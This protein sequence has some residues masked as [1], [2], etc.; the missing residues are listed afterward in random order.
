[1]VVIAEIGCSGLL[2]LW[3]TG[4]T[5]IALTVLFVAGA[6]LLAR[7]S[8]GIIWLAE[9]QSGVR[10][11]SGLL[12]ASC[13]TALLPDL[14]DLTP[15]PAK[16]LAVAGL[17]MVAVSVL[18]TRNVARVPVVSIL[19]TTAMAEHGEA[20]AASPTEIRVDVVHVTRLGGGWIGNLY[21]LMVAWSVMTLADSL[22]GGA[23]NTGWNQISVV[24]VVAYM[25]TL[26]AWS[27]AQLRRQLNAES[28][29][30]HMR[31][32]H[33]MIDPVVGDVQAL[34]DR[35]R[36]A[37]RLRLL[38]FSAGSLPLLVLVFGSV[39]IPGSQM[40]AI[41]VVLF[42]IAVVVEQGREFL[43]T[44]S[45]ALVAEAASAPGFVVDAES[46]DA[47]SILEWAQARWADVNARFR[48]VVLAFV[49][50]S[51]LVNLFSIVDFATKVVR[52]V[53]G[54]LP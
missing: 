44:A 43:T 31:R 7:I 50:V 29:R 48:Y 34:L 6:V 2:G 21:A 51:F 26:V 30:D 20:L 1:M 47:S 28:W 46:P 49:V 45:D 11:V 39:R 24:A 5:T 13:A 35:H 10:L 17:P 27:E 4:N 16:A 15:S 36:R 42:V 18:A 33:Q 41:V 38:V 14:S 22:S 32:A 25:L 9:N 19:D 12:A 3:A 54:L 53:E 8:Q 40:P 37:A 23:S 52:F